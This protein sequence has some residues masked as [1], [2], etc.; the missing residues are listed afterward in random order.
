MSRYNT[1]KNNNNNNNNKTDLIKWG[2]HFFFGYSPLSNFYK[3]EFTYKGHLVGS[4]EQAYMYEKA[5]YFNDLDRLHELTQGP[6]TP[7]HAKSLGRKVKPFNADEWTAVSYQKM[8]EALRV[9]FNEPNLKQLLI[10]THNLILVEASPFDAIWGIKIGMD[11]LDKL[12]HLPNFNGQNLL[13]K[14]LMQVRDE[15]N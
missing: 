1:N 3:Q 10:N 15:L 7:Q 2:H 12:T 5:L 8:V 9:K 14:A 11:E 13:G 4:L 6:I